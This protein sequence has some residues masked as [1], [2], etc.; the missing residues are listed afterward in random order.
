MHAASQTVL[1]SLDFSATDAQRGFRVANSGGRA[2]MIREKENV[3]PFLA[4]A[5]TTP[6]LV[7]AR[8]EARYD[9]FGAPG[10]IAPQP[11]GAVSGDEGSG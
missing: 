7:T 4:E 2:E 1:V 6:I 5:R 10:V 9:F 8:E 3:G 11:G